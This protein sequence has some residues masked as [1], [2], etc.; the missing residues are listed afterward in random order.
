MFTSIEY[1][2]GLLLHNDIYQLFCCSIDALSPHQPVCASADSAGGPAGARQEPARSQ[3]LQAS[4]LEW[5]EH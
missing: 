2:T 5:R 3:A 1:F 4:Q